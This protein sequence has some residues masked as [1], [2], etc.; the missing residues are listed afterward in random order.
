MD[1]SARLTDI[2]RTKD[3]PR[4][5]LLRPRL[6]AMPL[7]MLRY[8]DPFLPFGKELL[9]AT[10]DL[11]SIVAFDLAA[12]M[13]LGAAGVVALE[14][15]I[16]YASA[17]GDLLTVLHGPFASADYLVA[18]ADSA[19]AVDG[20]TVSDPALVDAYAAQHEA[21]VF[22]VTDAAD[23]AGSRLSFAGGHAALTVDAQDMRMTISLAGE[24]VIY[25]GHDEDFA[26]VARQRLM[27]MQRD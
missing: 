8:D 17:G 10:R 20:L 19:F 21:G 2:L 27:E 24:D 16:H 3:A 23:W 25:A 6:A 11:L 9:A 14:R 26:Q 12:Y 4:G 5:L 13:A 15:T 18:T 7:P 1:F 22:Y